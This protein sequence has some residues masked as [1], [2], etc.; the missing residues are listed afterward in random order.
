MGI[1]GLIPFLEKSSSKVHLKDL[2]GTTVAVDTYCWL[3]KGVFSCADKICRGED[4]DM[5]VTYCLKYVSMLLSF[6]IKPILVFDGRHLPAKALTEKRRRENRDVSR[7]KA[8]E[9]LRQGKTTEAHS[10][11][12]RCIDVTHDMA[13]R[14]IKECRLRN[15]DCIVAPYEADA[16]M[17]FLN[18]LDIAQYVITEDSDLTLF[19]C[20]K[21]IFKLDLTGSGL[22]VEA[23]KLYLSMGCRQ[24]K[25]T[26]DKFRTM[27]IL[28]G[29]DYL[30]SLPGIG[31]AKACKFVLMTEEDDM[32]RALP[33]IPQYLNKRSLEVNGDYV[34]NFLKA[35]A[36]FKHMYVYNPLERRMQRLNDLE[37]FKTDE[38]YCSNAGEPLDDGI[39]FQLALG[40]LNPF[41]LKVLDTWSPDHS[42]TFS[43]VKRTKHKS[44]W[45]C[46]FTPHSQTD[47]KQPV[48]SFAIQFKKVDYS[49][50]KKEEEPEERP[51]EDEIVSMYNGPQPPKK[52]ICSDTDN[53]IIRPTELTPTKKTSYNPFPM[54]SPRE[55]KPI[56]EL[57]LKPSPRKLPPINP[58]KRSIFTTKTEVRSRFFASNV[59]LAGEN[60]AQSETETKTN[61]TLPEQ[62]SEEI[63]EKVTRIEEISKENNEK[64]VALYDYNSPSPVKNCSIKSEKSPSTFIQPIKSESATQSQIPPSFDSGISSMRT[65][66]SGSSTQISCRDIG[67]KRLKEEDDDNVIELSDNEEKP[68][69]AF[70]K[71]ITPKKIQPAKP[72]TLGLSKVKR[73]N[74]ITSKV[75]PSNQTRLSMFGFQKKP[76]LK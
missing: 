74:S 56:F 18:K 35:D 67:V 40:N 51:E 34:E 6:D 50:M 33:K 24:E 41:S 30:D 7:K 28:S 32:R 15:V 61:P 60:N 70:K 57:V 44:I 22:L 54:V 4:T 9:L 46:N 72:R 73:T 12:R 69:P 64:K 19:G 65:T 45:Q 14:L 1:T 48:I 62:T 66:A 39:A 16:Q 25:Y 29:C 3:H 17:A 21:I 76:S 42:Q 20:K 27:C 11:M 8:A 43:N 71:I 13:L 2:R 38:R 55:K 59:S 52:R 36:T 75:V 58:F 5:Y 49:K 31:L 10:Q 47:K 68:T 23:D 26:F 63:I 53:C 37:I